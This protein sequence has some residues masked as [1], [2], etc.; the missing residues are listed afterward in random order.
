[1]LATAGAFN[2]SRLILAVETVETAL[3]ETK[4][5]MQPHKKGE[6][7]A[8]VYELFGEEENTVEVQKN[9]LRLIKSAV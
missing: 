1:M 4:R 9:V 7:G 5:T 3:L 2:K 8:A 6:R